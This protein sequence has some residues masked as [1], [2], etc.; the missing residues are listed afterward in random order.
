[1]QSPQSPVERPGAALKVCASAQAVLER[2]LASKDGQQCGLLWRAS[3]G[4]ELSHG[5]SEAAKKVFL[6]GIHACPWSKVC[7][8]QMMHRPVPTAFCAAVICFKPHTMQGVH[9]EASLCAVNP[10]RVGLVLDWS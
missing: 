7:G 2:G 1:M 8:L 6:R 5:R 4:F 10:N 3:L 9:T